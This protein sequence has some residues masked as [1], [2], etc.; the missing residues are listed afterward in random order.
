MSYVLQVKSTIK[1]AREFQIFES[2]DL[3]SGC[4]T[5]END[6][7]PLTMSSECRA[8]SL[9][10]SGPYELSPSQ[11]RRPIVRSTAPKLTVRIFL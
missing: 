2:P 6:P 9:R 3:L 5:R 4:M 10:S 7:V 1:K 8:T 11:V